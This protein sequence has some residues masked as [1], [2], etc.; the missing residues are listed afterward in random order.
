MLTCVNTGA[1]LLEIAE[2]Y[3]ITAKF[4]NIL[5]YPLNGQPLIL[6]SKVSFPFAIT[7]SKYVKAV[8]EGDQDKR[9]V[10]A[11]GLGDYRRRVSQDYQR[12]LSPVYRGPKGL[13]LTTYCRCS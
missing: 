11:D 2:T 8:V 3:G 1:E 9:L 6:K 5:R 7:E 12:E 13:I 4:G 10:S